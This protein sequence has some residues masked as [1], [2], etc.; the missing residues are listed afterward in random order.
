MRNWLIRCVAVVALVFPLPALAA[1]GAAL[2]RQNGCGDCHAVTRPA[3]PAPTGA[4]RVLPKGP[5]LWF[6]GSKLKPGWLAAWLENP[7]PVR[8]LRYDVIVPDTRRPPHPAVPKAEAAA[9]AAWL[10]GLTDSALRRGVIPEEPPSR[11]DMLQGRILFSKEQQ[12]FA[13][14]RIVTRHGDPVGGS[15]G[16]DLSGMATRLQPDWVY[17]YLTDPLRYEPNSRMPLYRGTDFEGYSDAQFVA[18]VRY[19]IS[20]GEAKP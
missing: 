11:R 6:A 10:G 17:A 3:T 14:H 19:L 2:F 15:S 13:C 4:E 9:I 16:P 8:G 12:C 18:L 7:V 20:I 1:D 5:P